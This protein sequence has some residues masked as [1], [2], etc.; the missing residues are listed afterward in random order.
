MAIPLVVNRGEKIAV[1]SSRV[2]TTKVK[3]AQ[4]SGRCAEIAAA[5]K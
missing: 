3:V 5:A 4:P 1:V 2:G